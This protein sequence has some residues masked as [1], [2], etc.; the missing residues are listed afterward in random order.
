M[1][2]IESAIELD[3]TLHRS[4]G[5]ARSSNICRASVSRILESGAII[6]QA[7]GGSDAYFTCDV[8]LG[9]AK[10]SLKT[11]DS[12]L[13]VTPASAEERGV[14][15]GQVGPYKLPVHASGSAE[16]LKLEA[17]ESLALKCGESSIEL[18]KDGKVLVKGK[19]IVSHAKRVQRIKGG[20]VAIN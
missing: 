17:T 10:L 3:E 5:K 13:V 12:V 19:D 2:P 9:D 15:L 1:N 7:A 18:R 8:L 20:T 14:V 6:V 4:T 16:H 11:G